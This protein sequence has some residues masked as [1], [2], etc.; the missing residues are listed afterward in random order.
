MWHLRS[1]GCAAVDPDNDND[2]D[3]DG[4]E[5]RLDDDDDDTV[6][7]IDEDTDGIVESITDDTDN[8]TVENYLDT[9]DDDDG[10]LTVGERLELGLRSRWVLSQ[11]GDPTKDDADNDGLANY[12]DSDDDDDGI[13]TS[14]EGG[15]SKN[16]MPP[17][18]TIRITWIR[19]DN[20]GFAD[21]REWTTGPD[22][23]FD[24]DGID[25]YLDSDPTMTR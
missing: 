1:A 6:D 3:E 13:P 2:S 19:S 11:Q 25:D 16:S 23:D 21:A 5:D 18:I 17:Q 9:D 8:D 14:Y 24:N 4:T 15:N 10:I 22:E 7:T 12:I 20:D